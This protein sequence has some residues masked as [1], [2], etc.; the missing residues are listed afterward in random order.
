MLLL[1]SA[2]PMLA[3]LKATKIERT[4]TT[5]KT[6]GFDTTEAP[7]GKDVLDTD[8]LKPRT[9]PER[10]Q[11][12]KNTLE[13]SRKDHGSLGALGSRGFSEKAGK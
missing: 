11:E 8:Q 3:R 1:I 13:A 5:M 12:S 7:R 4:T 10:F 2:E 9:G 6:F